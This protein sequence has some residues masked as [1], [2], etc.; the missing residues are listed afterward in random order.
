M[1]LF[2]IAKKG[3]QDIKTITKGIKRAY[4]LEQE[5]YP[6]LSVEFLPNNKYKEGIFFIIGDNVI[7]KDY[8]LMNESELDDMRKT[9]WELFPRYYNVTDITKNGCLT[10]FRKL[11]K[12]KV[13][14]GWDEVTAK[15]N[16]NKL[17]IPDTML[18]NQDTKT[19]EQIEKSI[20]HPVYKNS[21]DDI[22]NR[23]LC[24]INRIKECTD[25]YPPNSQVYKLCND[26]V[27]WL[28]NNGYP[29]NIRTKIVSNIVKKEIED[30]LKYLKD[31]NMKADKQHYDD[32]IL[33]GFFERPA[34]R[35]GNKYTDPNGG[36]HAIDFIAERGD[37]Y[38][39]YSQLIEGYDNNNSSNYCNTIMVIILVIIGI[40]II[41][42][43]NKK[44]S[45]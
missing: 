29:N 1:K 26:N 9:I 39:Y 5:F 43:I 31:T 36:K 14:I 2:Y 18:T 38:K 35:M 30:S 15:A 10:D 16:Y 6:H 3:C 40:I 32:F 7:H 8:F 41:Y 34:N 33:S 22:Q 12:N 45:V 23:K 37:D 25:N 19:D 11:G 44:S 4:Q 17:Y 28:C 27:V 13:A 24:L 21:G 20:L 42:V